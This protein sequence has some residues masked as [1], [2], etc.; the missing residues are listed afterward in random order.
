M[1]QCVKAQGIKIEINTKNLESS[2]LTSPQQ[3]LYPLIREIGVP[4]IVNS[5]AHLPYN[6]DS[7]LRQAHQLLKN[8]GIKSINVFYDNKWQETEI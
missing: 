7:G 6:V 8:A 4:V 2:G 5:D 1:L 3:D